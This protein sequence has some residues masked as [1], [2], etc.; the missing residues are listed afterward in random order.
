MRRTTLVLSFLLGAAGLG[1][2]G[3][4]QG[5]QRSN[6]DVDV[7][8]ASLLQQD[9]REGCLPA[10]RSH[11]RFKSSRCF[12]G[13]FMDSAYVFSQDGKRFVEGSCI[14]QQTS[15]TRSYRSR[16][17]EIPPQNNPSLC[18]EKIFSNKKGFERV[19]IGF[20]IYDDSFI[21]NPFPND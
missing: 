3:L 6:P 21:V 16:S 19:P 5:Q 18:W 9:V 11:G 17:V 20:R 8:E 13:A 1:L 4:A 7:N 14:V 15:G 10:Q 2:I 12:A